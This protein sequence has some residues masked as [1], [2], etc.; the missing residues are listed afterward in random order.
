MNEENKILC[1]FNFRSPYAYLGVKKALDCNLNLEFVPFCYAPKEILEAIMVANPFKSTYLMEDCKRIF[2]EEDII[3]SET[4]AADCNWPKVHAAWLSAEKD[5]RGLNFMNKAFEFRWQKGLDLGNKNVIKSLCEEIDYDGEKAVLAMDNEE[6]DKEL[7]SLT[8]LSRK[9]Q[10]F[11][12]P[13][14]IYNNERFW[15]QDRVNVLTEKINL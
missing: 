12:V 7:K 10:V 6:Y 11:G 1:F 5:G 13:I 8:K 14:F 9:Y 2:K 15:G 3:L 4:I